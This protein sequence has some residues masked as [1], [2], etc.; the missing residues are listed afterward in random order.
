MF[1]NLTAAAL[2]KWV[3]ARN[4]SLCAVISSHLKQN[5][6]AVAG[7]SSAA[8]NSTARNAN[9]QVSLADK[10]VEVETKRAK[11]RSLLFFCIRKVLGIQSGIGERG[12]AW[13]LAPLERTR[14]S[15][16]GRAAPAVS[17]PGSPPC[18]KRLRGRTTLVTN[19]ERREKQTPPPSTRPRGGTDV[20]LSSSVASAVSESSWL[21]ARPVQMSCCRTA[22]AI[23]ITMAVV[24]VLLSHMERKTVQHMKPSTSLGGRQGWGF[25]TD[26]GLVGGGRTGRH[27]WGTT[28]ESLLVHW[29]RVLV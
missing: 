27:H 9:T 26:G 25:I 1:H 7:E 28:E 11:W 17:S 24:D 16:C 21:S 12:G 2:S 6:S 18:L 14:T 20:P 8:A 15:R 22:S 29:R 19:R 10:C 4:V 5:S 13:P 3:E 23:G